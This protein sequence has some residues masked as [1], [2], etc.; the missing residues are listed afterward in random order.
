MP[1]VGP[2]TRRALLTHLRALGFHGP[3]SGTR[4]QFMIQGGRNVF[5]PNPHAGA[6]SRGLLVRILKHAGIDRT[7]WEKL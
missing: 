3:V 4:H 5:I 2:I 6:I 1:P 7:A